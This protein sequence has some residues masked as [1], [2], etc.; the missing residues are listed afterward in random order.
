MISSI[1]RHPWGWASFAPILCAIHCAAT[2]L[3]V[4]ALPA[5]A[6]GETVERLLFG[7]TLVLAATALRVGLGSHGKL[8]VLIP[9]SLGLAAWAAS[10]WGAFLPIP[11]AITTLP[12]A[13]VVAGGLVWN[14]REQCGDPSVR[15]SGCEMEALEPAGAGKEA[16]CL[17]PLG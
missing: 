15:C 9:V 12:A 10:L 5:F 8:K 4:L 16:T 6:F 1:F 7:L 14:S 17:N 3:V 11:E 2:P 13:L